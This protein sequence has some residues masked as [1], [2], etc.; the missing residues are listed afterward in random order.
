MRAAR[1]L[2]EGRIE[3]DE[4]PA[5]RPARDEVR[6]RVH[7]C[8]L[9]G[10]DRGQYRGGSAATPGHEISGTIVEV[11]AAVDGLSPGD[12]GV[13]YLVD[14]CGSCSACR[15]GSTNVCLARR[16]MYGFTA[17]GGFAEELVVRAQCFLTV[18][19]LPLDGATALLDLFGT[20]LHALRRAALRPPESVAVLGCGPIGLGAVAVA[21]ALGAAEVYAV[22]V[23]AY[24]LALAARLGATPV[25]GRDG[26]AVAGVL[27]CAPDGCDV[28][29]EAAGLAAT[30]RQ[31]IEL[32]APG[33]RAVV[34]AHS[35][36]PLEL[37]P[38]ADLIERER[39]LVGC[40]YFP[41]AAFE[42][43]HALVAAG[44]LDPA[45]LLTHRFPLERIGDAYELFLAGETGK[46]LVHP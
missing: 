5:P 12:A 44:R 18:G 45:P 22:D 3:L 37:R 27:A 11:G 41:L 46:V 21:R 36:Q 39:S 4:R 33:G 25:S 14:F 17:D 2:G 32:T 28:V 13:V 29:L 34:L 20:T 19:E 40:E 10:S 9:C 26:D 16:R 8:A 30:Q 1:F 43:T 42:E 31:A 35:Q 38:S 6:V 23:V 7:S 15:V 24:R